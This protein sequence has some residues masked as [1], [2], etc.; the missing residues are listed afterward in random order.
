MIA[1]SSEE[2]PIQPEVRVHSVRRRR[3]TR[4]K[5]L[6]PPPPNVR[7]WLIYIGLALLVAALMLDGYLRHRPDHALLPTYSQATEV[8]STV[9]EVSDSLQVVVGWELTLADPTRRPDSVRVTVVTGTRPDSQTSIQPSSQLSDTLYLPAPQPGQTLSG[10]SCAAARYPG[11]PLE[12]SCT[13]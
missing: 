8:H 3:S 13:P 9:A 11:L 1:L 10:V 12:Q 2:Q 4:P 7:G 6:T 5:P